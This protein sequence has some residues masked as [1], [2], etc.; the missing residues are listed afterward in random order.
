MNTQAPVPG[1]A[2]AD[3]PPVPPA[4]ALLV[5]VWIWAVNFPVAKLGLNSLTPL[6]FNA[7]RFP[8]GAL[9]VFTA[10]RSRGAIPLPR[11]GDRLRI[12]GLG[13]LGNLVYQQFFIFGL[14]R[15]RAG[16]AS[17]LLA[18]TPIITAFL[19][20]AVGHEKVG[21]RSWVGACAT[22]AGMVFVVGGGPDDGSTSLAGELLLISSSFAWAGY[23]VGSRS[24][25]QRYGAV[26][27]AAWTLCVGAT[28]VFLV[29]LP[30]VVR[31][32]LSSLTLGAW[33]SVIYAG[34]ISIGV[35]YL[36]W[37]YGVR[38]LGNTR[39]SVFS[40]LVPVFALLVAWLW[41]GEVPLPFQVLGASII[42]GGV[43]LVQT[44]RGPRANQ[45]T[46]NTAARGVPE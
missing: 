24:F 22:V 18:G 27:V 21:W 38:H 37:Y 6:A 8:L 1:S 30:S 20:S 33:L 44:Q 23:T 28:A 45:R 3:A 19:S 25:I 40:N 29:G 35:A 7:L 31:T 15:T 26:P 32:D 12:V 2:T 34:G 46:R 10:L 43:M 4:L 14:D 13:L 9:V 41:L 42:I 16:T 17:I 5:M 36:I 39:T 11:R